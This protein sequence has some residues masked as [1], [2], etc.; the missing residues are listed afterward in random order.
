LAGIKKILHAT[1][2]SKA[3]ARA[4]QEAIKLARE[5]QA[6][7]LVVHVIEPTPYVAGGEFGGAEIYTKLEDM[8]KRNAQSS[9]TK[10]LQ[11]LKKLKIKAESLLLRGSSHDQIVKAAKSK[12]ADMIVI[13][14]HGRTG[15]SKLFMGS[16]AGKVVSLA[17]CPVM[18][19]RG[20]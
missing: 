4:L 1:D 2:F 18:T 3:S 17:T 19:V 11:R 14:T 16:V 12:K 8:A 20:K 5:N 7:L 9:M 13:G 6:R 15:L 10:L